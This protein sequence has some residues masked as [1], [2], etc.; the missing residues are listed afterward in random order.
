VLKRAAEIE[1]RTLAD[2]VV[3]AALDAARRT[4]SRSAVE[5]LTS[6]ISALG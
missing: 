4:W 1:G 2:F 5:N 3:S 6:Q